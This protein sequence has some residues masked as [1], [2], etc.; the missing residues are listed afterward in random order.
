MKRYKAFMAKY[1][2]GEDANSGI[3]TYGYSTAALLVQILKQCGDNLTHTNIMKQATNIKDYVADLALPGMT[4]STEP[5]D[6]RINKQFQMMKFD[7]QRWVLFGPIVTNDSK[8]E[9]K[10][11]ASKTTPMRPRII[12]ALAS[13]KRPHNKQDFLKF[14]RFTACV[15]VRKGMT[16]RTMTTAALVAVLSLG[17]PAL[18]QAQGASS[19]KDQAPAESQAPASFSVSIYSI[20]VID[21]KE[22]PPAVKSQVDDIVA[23]TSEED[24]QSLRKSIDGT[25]AAISALKAEGLTSAQ[26]VAINIADGVLMLFTKTA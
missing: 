14:Q 9:L 13:P 10:F 20:Q 1:A 5:D 23:K 22:L 11:E 17:T 21:V 18:V 2:P 6:W 3:A 8:D 25:P 26:V 24:K 7:R 12:A 16:M 15:I 19:Q 4:T